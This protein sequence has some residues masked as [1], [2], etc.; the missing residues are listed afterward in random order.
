MP[1][2]ECKRLHP[3]GGCG[4]INRRV[5]VTGRA[6][7]NTL[8]L[9]WLKVKWPFIAVGW[10]SLVVSNVQSALQANKQAEARNKVTRN[11]CLPPF[12][13]RSEQRARPSIQLEDH[14]TSSSSTSPSLSY[15]TFHSPDYLPPS[16]IKS[17]PRHPTLQLHRPRYQ[18]PCF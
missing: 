15:I 5:M 10:V 8:T 13:H 12:L 1:G 7:S 14:T 16:L 4:Q 2:N 11:G 18:T 17:S 9:E 6:A 3:W